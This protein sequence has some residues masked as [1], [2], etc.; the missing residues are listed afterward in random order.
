MLSWKL[1]CSCN[2]SLPPEENDTL[3]AW[4][5][6]LFPADLMGISTVDVTIARVRNLKRAQC[7]AGHRHVCT[8]KLALSHE[9]KICKFIVC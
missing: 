8:T 5:N 4:E 6:V 3:V 9:N 2:Y 1:T 7:L